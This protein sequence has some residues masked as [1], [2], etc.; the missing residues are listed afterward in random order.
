MEI[1]D[2]QQNKEKVLNLMKWLGYDSK[3]LDKDDRLFTK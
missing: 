1:W 2:D 3:Q